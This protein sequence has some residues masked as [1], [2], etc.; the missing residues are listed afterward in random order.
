M[1][2]PEDIRPGIVTPGMAAALQT[3]FGST[4]QSADTLQRAQQPP[5]TVIMP[6]KITSVTSSKYAWTLQ[7][8]DASGNRIDH[9]SGQT[10]TAT[11]NPAYDPNGLID[12]FPCHAYIRPFGFVASLGGTIYEVIGTSTSGTTKTLKIQSGASNAFGYPA[13]VQTW[14]TT[15]GSWSD[16]NS[17]EVRVEDPNGSPFGVGEYVANA[18]LL[19][20]N[21]SSVVC[22]AAP[23]NVGGGGLEP[24]P[25][26]KMWHSG[27][28]WFLYPEQYFTALTFTQTGGAGLYMLSVSA[29]TWA[30]LAP[31]QPNVPLIVTGSLFTGGGAF[32]G[33]SGHSII[34]RYPFPADS[35][36][37]FGGFGCFTTMFKSFG[38]TFTMNYDTWYRGPVLASC[39]F[40]VTITVTKLKHGR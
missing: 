4:M 23:E 27:A 35:E 26:V 24:L 16:L 15:A 9:P 32:E 28:G 10:G 38:E 22:Y 19:G 31:G 36:I 21:S 12:A 40:Q 14:S 8:K 20:T 3:G 5:D 11:V 37:M 33:V 17:T 2:A 18:R 13:R 29:S 1:S 34:E 25:W 30:L 7:I 39:T 6:V